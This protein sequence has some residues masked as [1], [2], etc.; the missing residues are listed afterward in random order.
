[1]A[2]YLFSPHAVVR[3][4]EMGLT[5]REVIFAL[6]HAECDYPGRPGSDGTSRR[7]STGG[8]LAVVYSRGQSPY[9]LVIVTV[10]W[11]GRISRS[12]A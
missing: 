10:L 3:M 7:V 4:N 11:N 6:E 5:V 12:A 1:M 9:P 8:R 2:R